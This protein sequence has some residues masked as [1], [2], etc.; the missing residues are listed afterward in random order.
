MFT[1]QLHFFQKLWRSMSCNVDIIHATT[2][3]KSCGANKVDSMPVV[4]SFRVKEVVAWIMSSTTLS[5][6]QLMERVKLWR[7]HCGFLV[8]PQLFSVRWIGRSRMNWKK[9][10]TYSVRATII[11]PVIASGELASS[12]IFSNFVLYGPRCR[13]KSDRQNQD[14]SRHA[15]NYRRSWHDR[16][17]PVLDLQH[18]PGVCKLHQL[19][20]LW[21]T[22]R[23]SRLNNIFVTVSRAFVTNIWKVPALNADRR[24]TLYITFIHHEGRQYEEI[25]R[26]Y[27]GTIHKTHKLKYRS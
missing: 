20:S 15:T 10:G 19:N 21:G 7:E 6:P 18:A 4:L 23:L 8:T 22:S 14:R 9:T 17:R 25:H 3:L 11:R 5:T 12:F 26:T 2:S 16:S 1:P 27:N 24:A 13:S